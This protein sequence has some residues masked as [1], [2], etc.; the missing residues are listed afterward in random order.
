M[1]LV[2]NPPTPTRRSYMCFVVIKSHY[3]VVFCGAE[4]VRTMVIKV[5]NVHAS[6]GVPKVARSQ[7]SPR[8]P[9][10]RGRNSGSGY[11]ALLASGRGRGSSAH[12]LRS[13]LRLEEI[14]GVLHETITV[15]CKT[16][17][18]FR[19]PGGVTSPGGIFLAGDHGG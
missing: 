18:F 5:S 12:R 17:R 9:C 11:S 19:A 3:A 1:K 8:R 16:R 15:S 6:K 10:L 4:R 13:G 2:V 7:K 14:R